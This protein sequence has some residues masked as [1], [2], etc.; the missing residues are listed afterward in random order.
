MK[1]LFQICTGFSILYGDDKP[2]D[3][4]KTSREYIKEIK[5]ISIPYPFALCSQKAVYVSCNETLTELLTD[6]G[7]CF[8]FNI[9]DST[10]LFRDEM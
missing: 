3:N 6:S 8:T 9:I 5:K 4:G 2:Y 7:I 10:E 1:T